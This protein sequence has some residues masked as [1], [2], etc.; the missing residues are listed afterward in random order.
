MSCNELRVLVCGGRTYDDEERV[1]RV[2]DKALEAAISTERRFVLIHGGAKG[3]DAL[4]SLW[5]ST[6]QDS[7]QETV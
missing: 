2:L 6:R 1:F 5:A 3:A 4:S 7:V